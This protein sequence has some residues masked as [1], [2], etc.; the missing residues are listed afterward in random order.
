VIWK[1][2]I[3]DSWEQQMRRIVLFIL[4][5]HIG[6]CLSISG[7]MLAQSSEEITKLRVV[8]GVYEA[9]LMTWYSPHLFPGCFVAQIRF[10]DYQF[11]ARDES[12][13]L[14]LLGEVITVGLP[15]RQSPGDSTYTRG[16]LRV[17]QILH[18]PR[19][20]AQM[21]SEIQIIESDGFEELQLDDRLILFMV[22]YEGEYAL[23]TWYC[24][25]SRLGVRLPRPGGNGYFDETGF[26]QLVSTRLNAPL[27]SLSADE[28]RIWARADPCGVAEAL[29]QRREML[30]DQH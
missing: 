2:Q 5:V 1:I 11:N 25:N 15:T 6:L 29:I 30:E 28:L 26:I 13:M 19:Q 21:V 17:E 20:Y 16:R 8:D 14:V 3:G 12:P 9:G 24:L 7:R 4:F 27:D 18:C 22:P 10:D 23:P